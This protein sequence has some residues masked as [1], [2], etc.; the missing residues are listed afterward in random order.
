MGK[1]KYD[2][3]S[4]SE[5]DFYKKVNTRLIELAEVDK[6]AKIIEL[7]TLVVFCVYVSQKPNKRKNKFGSFPKK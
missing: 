6:L 5:L 2:F 1:P 3:S 4:F 7:G